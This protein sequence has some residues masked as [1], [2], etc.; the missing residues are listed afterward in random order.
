VSRHKRRRGPRLHWAPRHAPERGASRGPRRPNPDLNVGRPRRIGWVT[1]SG[2]ARSVALTSG[3]LSIA[4]EGL[5][6]IGYIRLYQHPA[7]RRSVLV[8]ATEA[9][10]PF[11]AEVFGALIERM[12]AAAMLLTQRETAGHI[13]AMVRGARAPVSGIA[14]RCWRRVTGLRHV[15]QTS[16]FR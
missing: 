15:V 11:E 6:R 10:A 8:E 5:E 12:N 2:L 13:F 9:I 1:P 3:G 16:A 4:L 7:D 14:K